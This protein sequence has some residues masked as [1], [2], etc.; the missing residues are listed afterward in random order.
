MNAN[1]HRLALSSRERVGGDEIRA[2]SAGIG[3][4][5]DVE[6]RMIAEDIHHA[7]AALPHRRR[8][9]F[10][11]S[12]F[13]GLTYHEIAETLGISRQTVANQMSTALAELRTSLSRHLS[14]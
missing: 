14:D 9:I 5:Q 12:R 13:H 4:G 6:D 11:L 2:Y 10:T 3:S 7:L 8:E 1:R